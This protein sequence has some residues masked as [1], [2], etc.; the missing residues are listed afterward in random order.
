[1]AVIGISS[2]KIDIISAAKHQSAKISQSSNWHLAAKISSAAAKR[3]ASE[4]SGEN[5][6]QSE[7]NMKKSREENQAAYQ[8]QHHQRKKSGNGSIGEKQSKYQ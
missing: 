8:R 2:A 3:K 6:H 5:G 4:E 7:E 1:M